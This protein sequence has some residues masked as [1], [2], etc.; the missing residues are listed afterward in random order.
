M[1]KI[2]LKHKK[3]EKTLLVG[4]FFIYFSKFCSLHIDE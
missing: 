2:T 1:V 3:L 4:N